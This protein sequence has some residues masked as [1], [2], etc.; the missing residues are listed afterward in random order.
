V[1]F[2]RNV[3]NALNLK[4]FINENSPKKAV[5]VGGG[6]IGLLIAESLVKLG[7]KVS[8]IEKSG[9]IFS[10]YEH[11]I[12]DILQK[13]ISS[14]EIDLKLNS[15]LVS[16]GLDDG[17][18]INAVSINCSGVLESFETDLIVL[19]TGIKANTDFCLQTSIEFGKNNAIKT[20]PKLQTSYSNIYASGDC[21]CV[22]NIITGKYDYIPTANNAAKTGRIAGENITGGN[23]TFPGSVGTKVDKIFGFEIART[24]ISLADAEELQFNAFKITEHYNSHAKAL[25]GVELITITVIIDFNTQRILGVQMIGKEGVAKRI[26]IFAAAITAQMTIDQVYMLDLSYSPG[27]STVWD[28]VN[29]ICGKAR[30]VLS[31]KRF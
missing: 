21:I 2:F 7:I 27:T 4:D 23:E 25:P 13:A 12:S 16:A 19:C 18:L 8:I 28:P 15:E 6:S 11:E 5:V 26:D 10:D 20:N 31:K 29:K 1:F 14:E 3:E 22:K 9:S 17:G 24:G 30:L